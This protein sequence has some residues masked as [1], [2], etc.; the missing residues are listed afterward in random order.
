[1]SASSIILL[2]VITR[3]H[4]LRGEV[5]LLPFNPASDRW[6]RA[7]ELLCVPPRLVPS[8]ETDTIVSDEALPSLTLEAVREGAKGRFIARFS[9]LTTRRHA[10]ES[11][12]SGL[13]VYAP[14]LEEPTDG[15]FWFHEVPGWAVEDRGGQLLGHIVQALDG[16]QDLLEVR[17]SS[18]GETFFIPVVEAFIVEVDRAN[19]RFIVEVPEGLIS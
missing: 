13:G 19:K 5:E 3:A 2:G 12:G 14:T 7:T 16:A 11:R 9:T 8:R 15:E 4:G 18:G 6:R 17:P 1:M 10:E